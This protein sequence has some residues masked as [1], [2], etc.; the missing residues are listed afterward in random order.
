[1]DLTLHW[2][3]I[4]ILASYLAIL[5]AIGIRFSGRQKNLEDF[6]LAQ[7]SMTW[8]PVG[9]S[10]MAALN[11]GIDYLMM[12]SAIATYGIAI[13]FSVLSWPLIYRYVS[14]VTLPFFN[15]LKVVTAYEYL[16]HRFDVRVRTLAAAI[17]ILWRLGWMGTA[18]YVPCLAISSATGGAIPLIPTIVLLG[19]VVIIYTMLGGIRAVIWTDVTQFCIMFGGLV[20]TVA[21][22]LHSMPGGIGEIFQYMH[23]S[24]NLNPTLIVP[25]ETNADFF[26][27]IA[28]FFTQEVSILGILL[29]YT[30]ARLTIYTCDQVMIQRFQTTKSVKDAR[31]AFVINAC[32]DTIWML[33]LGFVGMALLAYANVNVFP[34]EVM[35]DRILPTVM[36]QTFP[37]GI[38]GLV[39]A[40]IFAAS[41]SSIDS[42]IN[43]CSSSVIVDFYI[44]L[45]Q[46]QTGDKKQVHVSRIAVVSLG[47]AAIFLAINVGRIGNLFEIMNKI[48]LLFTGPLFAIFI[49]GMFTRWARNNGVLIGGLVGAGVSIYVAFFTRISF[50]WPSIFGLIASLIVGTVMSLIIS[51]ST[52]PSI[53][54]YSDIMNTDK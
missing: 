27:R 4:I 23:D 19:G 32:G 47:I 20:A 11:S 46:K 14:R 45:G 3:D 37:A 12:P 6:F 29:M 17:F 28:T 5:T 15:K 24:G 18:L 1:M 35:G 22:A 34:S 30:I 54:T 33:G 36:A 41:L 31:N 52:V 13:L 21:I 7:R 44:R 16:E 51:S 39:V 26:T 53:L 9:L 8:L 49:L 38:V 42:A 43:A 2:L 10:L 25:P 50:L 48:I 40:A